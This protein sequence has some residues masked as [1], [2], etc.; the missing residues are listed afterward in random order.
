[1]RRPAQLLS[2]NLLISPFKSTN[3]PGQVSATSDA[4]KTQSG[5][6]A[7]PLPTT[8]HEG[9]A[10]HTPIPRIIQIAKSVLIYLREVVRPGRLEL[11]T[12]WFVGIQYK[13]LSAA[14]GVA[15]RG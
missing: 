4:S 10:R 15:Y 8:L 1:M 7:N 2:I 9:T 6:N 3:L 11:L 12:F 5:L 14:S 13:T